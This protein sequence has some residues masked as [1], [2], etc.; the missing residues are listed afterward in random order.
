[1]GGIA[2]GAVGG[3]AILGVIGFF[4]YRRRESGGAATEIAQEPELQTVDVKLP[5][6][7]FKSGEQLNN[8]QIV[9]E[10]RVVR[11][12]LTQ[13]HQYVATSRNIKTANGRA[14]LLQHEQEL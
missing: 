9:K 10:Y 1:M 7:A 3:I 11:S 12:A 8:M 5:T 4:L 13:R 6:D 2:V 14:L